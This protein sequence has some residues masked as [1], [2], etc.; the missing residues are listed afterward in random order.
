MIAL[1]E[2][3]ELVVDFAFRYTL[4]AIAVRD[5]VSAPPDCMHTQ[6]DEITYFAMEPHRYLLLSAAVDPSLGLPA[7]HPRPAS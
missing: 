5:S 3:W 4:L 1:M 6:C 2:V 7:M